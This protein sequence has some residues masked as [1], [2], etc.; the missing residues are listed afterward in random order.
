MAAISALDGRPL[1]W[2]VLGTLH[3]QDS[4]AYRSLPSCWC[5]LS[6]SQALKK[7]EAVTQREVAVTEREAKCQVRGRGEGTDGTAG[8]RRDSR[9]G[10][11]W[12]QQDTRTKSCKG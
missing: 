6:S 12:G 8:R 10:R 2:H 1:P 11:G 9:A 4:L 7:A 3:V 5:P